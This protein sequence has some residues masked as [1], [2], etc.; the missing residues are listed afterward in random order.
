MVLLNFIIYTDEK[1]RENLRRVENLGTYVRCHQKEEK[2]IRKDMEMCFYGRSPVSA[3]K[4][5]DRKSHST[6]KHNVTINK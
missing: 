1:N 3:S 4:K 2:K 5:Q 6:H